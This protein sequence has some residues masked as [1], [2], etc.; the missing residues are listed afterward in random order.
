MMKIR[1]TKTEDLN[2]IDIIYQNAKQ[3]MRNNGNKYQWNSSYPNSDDSKKDMINKHSFVI[4]N[5]YNEI[6]GTFA[7]ILGNDPTYNYIVNGDWLNNEEYG[8][9]HRIAALRPGL[10]ILENTVNYCFNFTNNIRIDTHKD[11]IVMQN[12]L[13]RLGFKYCGIIYLKNKE[14]RLAYQLVK[15]DY[16]MLK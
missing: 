16:L 10:N 12:A 11:N 14:E 13:K 2:I 6:I 15:K 7:F 3:F 9:I 4:V 5:D 1:E 8:V